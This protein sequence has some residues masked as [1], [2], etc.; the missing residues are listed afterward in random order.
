M[1]KHD[2]EGEKSVLQSEKRKEEQRGKGGGG[3]GGERSPNRPRM[4]QE[5]LLRNLITDVSPGKMICT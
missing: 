2:T 3:G 1:M 5:S 4:F